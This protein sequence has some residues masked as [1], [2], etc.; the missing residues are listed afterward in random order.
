[1]SQNLYYS[2]G[3]KFMKSV[4][5]C[6]CSYSILSVG[7][8][9]LTIVSGQEY[10]Y[11]KT[12][13]RIV[14]LTAFNRGEKGNCWEEEQL[15]NHESVFRVIFEVFCY[16]WAIINHG[17]R[18]LQNPQICL[19]TRVSF[20]IEDKANVVL[21]KLSTKVLQ[22][23]FLGPLN[24]GVQFEDTKVWKP[25]L[26]Q[27]HALLINT[28]WLLSFSFICYYLFPNH[29]TAMPNS[30][31]EAQRDAV[32]WT[33]RP[34]WQPQTA[35]NWMPRGTKPTAER[36]QAEVLRRAHVL[37]ERRRPANWPPQNVSIGWRNCRLQLRLHES[38]CVWIL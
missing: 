11:K 2:R 36:L 23:N 5:T 7:K 1:M 9:A 10:T 37:W 27:D 21:P 29:S 34:G 12:E 28:S 33:I 35:S 31:T 8:I 3:Q 17:I 18:F 13:T 6:I 32:V 30:L 14:A 22:V 20:S 19:H 16:S 15:I 38:H 24:L 4:N 26:W 25:K